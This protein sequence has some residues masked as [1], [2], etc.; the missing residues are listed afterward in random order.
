M[1]GQRRSVGGLPRRVR[2]RE[3][4]RVAPDAPVRAAGRAATPEHVATAVDAA[5]NV[6]VADPV[7][8]EI[9]PG[10]SPASPIHITATGAVDGANVTFTVDIASDSPIQLANFILDGVYLGGRGDDQRHYVLTRML[11]SGV[12]RLVVDVTDVNGA[13]STVE[14]ELEV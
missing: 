1:D 7:S 10:T 11:S 8:F 12:H 9:G 3:R 2:D 5:G 14:V 6:G 4:P 13:S